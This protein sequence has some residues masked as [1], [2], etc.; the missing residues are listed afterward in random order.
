MSEETGPELPP[1]IAAAWG[2]RDRPG[3]GPKRALSVG[4]IVDAA[5]R[6]AVTDGLA[7]VSMNRV[8]AE[9][10]TAAMS[11]YRY[12]SGKDELLMLMRDA[13]AVPPDDIPAPDENW[14]AGLTRWASALR[15]AYLANPWVLKIPITG[16]PM[17]PNQVGWMERGLR[18]LTG[19]TLTEGDKMSALLLLS[20]Y[21]HSDA[22]LTVSLE[23]SFAAA[24]SSADD[25]VVGYDKTLR[26]LVDPAQFPAITA[27]LEAG[28]FADAGTDDEDFEFGLERILDGLEVLIEQ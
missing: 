19:A 28:V 15:A 26:Q 7:A 1:S 4:Q 13:A 11:L 18:C 12:V 24:G 2:L 5:I 10:G 23:E 21:V 8:A 27:V 3:K 22:A 9:I 17:T 25:V 14:R 6:A 20:G 16:P